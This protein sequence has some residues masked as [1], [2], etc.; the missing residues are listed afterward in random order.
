MDSTTGEKSNCTVT[1]PGALIKDQASFALQIPALS[2]L[3][4]DSF[5][6]S[7][8]NLFSNLANQ[9]LSGVNGLL[10]LGGSSANTNNSFGAS[11]NLS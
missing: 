2:L 7:V 5:N 10:G 11:G 1:T 9:A 8:G 6:E 4:A 3:N